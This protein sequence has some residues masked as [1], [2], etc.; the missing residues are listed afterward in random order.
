MNTTNRNY[1]KLNKSNAKEKMNLDKDRNG[2]KPQLRSFSS[3]RHF[4]KTVYIGNMSYNKKEKDIRYL[5]AKYGKIDFL[6][7]I[8]DP[9][10]GKSKGFAFVKM[11]KESEAAIAIKE[12][13]GKIID[14]RTLK[15]SEAKEQPQQKNKRYESKNY[16]NDANKEDEFTVANKKPARKKKINGLDILFKNTKSTPKNSNLKAR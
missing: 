5:F 15:V 3:V 10:T 7:I 4:G 6:E 2:D 16:K 14:G 8:A 12:L 9:E 13:N 11:F 1:K